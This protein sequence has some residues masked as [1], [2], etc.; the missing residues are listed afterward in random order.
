MPIPDAELY[1]HATGLAKA[2]ADKHSEPQDLK[3]YSGWFCPFGMVP[4][5]P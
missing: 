2:T 3:L 4:G 5:F 1:P